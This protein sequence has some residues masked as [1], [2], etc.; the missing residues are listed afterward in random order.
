M[1]SKPSSERKIV[2]VIALAITAVFLLLFLLTREMYWLILA[3]LALACWQA[4]ERYLYG[5]ENRSLRQQ[6]DLVQ[7]ERD[8][9][10][11]Q[12]ERQVNQA[13]AKLKQV[14]ETA[15]AERESRNRFWRHISHELR[16]PLNGIINFSHMIG[17][18]FYG[19]VTD[20]QT[21]YLTRIEQSGWY[22]LNMLNDLSDLAKIEAGELALNLNQVDLKVVC[23]E[24][25]ATLY[26]LLTDDSVQI[27]RDYPE[28]FPALT[29]DERR[30]K[31]VLVNLLRHAAKQVE[32]GFIALRVRPS[33]QQVEIIVEDTAEGVTADQLAS[34][35][36]DLGPESTT[37]HAISANFGLSVARYLVEAHGGTLVVAAKP[38]GGHLFTLTLPKRDA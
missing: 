14:Q 1:D 18:G 2:V 6:L 12:S 11:A 28:H 37:P 35:F 36:V 30:L 31:Q 5:R 20:R 24:S 34:L 8:T 33:S 13:Q 15:V 32:D 27:M 26:S 17:L 21:N 25:L 7:G 29:A 3:L 16:T 38:N 22:L 23:E 9:L 19:E 4:V 10:Q